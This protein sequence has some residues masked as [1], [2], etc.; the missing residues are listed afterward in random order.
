[1]IGTNMSF[2][3]HKYLPVN[4]VSQPTF[5]Q[6]PRIFGDAVIAINLF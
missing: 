4:T 1:M 6:Y 5:S 3:S 2:F